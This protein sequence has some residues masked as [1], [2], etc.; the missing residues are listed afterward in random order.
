[1]CVSDLGMERLIWKSI[2]ILLDEET[3]EVLKYIT[4]L[5]Y[6]S[7]SQWIS[8]SVCEYF[9]DHKL[10]IEDNRGNNENSI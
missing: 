7:V 4:I 8:D 9:K 10:K 6:E 2:N 5:C 1:M 3:V